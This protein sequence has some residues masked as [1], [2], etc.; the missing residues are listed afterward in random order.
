MNRGL[1][2]GQTPCTRGLTP[3]WLASALL[4]LIPAASLPAAVTLSTDVRPVVFGVMRLDEEQVLAQFGSYHNEI[5]C[6]S[7]N[8]QAWYLKV[9]ALQPLTSGADVIPLE[10][11]AWELI[12]S[13]GRGSVAHPNAF[14]PFSLMPDLAYLSGPDEG[15]G[16]PVQ[17]RFRYRLRIPARQTSGIYHTTIR[18]T[19]TELY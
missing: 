2:R 7:T 1:K 13:T 19:F 15:D 16:A 6:S 4:A 5:T 8:G 12:Q 3:L 17:L 14:T 9:Q 11:F 10:A 18:F